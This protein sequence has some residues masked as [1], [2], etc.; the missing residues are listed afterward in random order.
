MI[1]TFFNINYEIEREN[2]LR[3]VDEYVNTNRMGYVV[4]ADGVIMNTANRVPDYLDVVNAS[5]FSI[6]DSSFVPMYIKWIH[7]V[8]VEQYCGSD[9]FG[10]IVGKK[11]YRM[12]FLGTKQATLDALRANL[13]KTDKRIEK[14]LFAELPF[15]EVE[16]FDYEAI[17]KRVNEYEAD[18]IWVALG[19]PKQEY[20]MNRLLPHL[21]K[22]VM[23]AVGAAFNFYSGTDE[24]RAP[25]WM[26]NH[27][28][29]FVYR[30]YKHPKK[31]L[32]RCAW[33]VLTLPGLLY[34]EW[35]SKKL[36][37]LQT[38]TIR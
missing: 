21:K 8:K 31:Q 20:F 32:N 14:M 29:E 13:S 12:A 3:Q 16:D 19:A 37:C 30:I 17:A 35:K 23:I 18:I 2:A 34:S 24:K 4:V 11:K 33:I 9:I 6:C 15:R 38:L 27:H 7:G 1:R 5:M 28:L 36:L 25:K 26:L 10:D 22:G